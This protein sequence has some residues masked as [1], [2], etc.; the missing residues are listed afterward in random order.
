[1]FCGSWSRTLETEQLA[2]PRDECAYACCTMPSDI[3]MCTASSEKVCIAMTCSELVSFTT[4]H[5]RWNGHFFLAAAQIGQAFNAAPKS[6]P[7][8]YP[9]M[10]YGTSTSSTFTCA[11]A[12]HACMC[13][14]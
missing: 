2:P 1:M 4:T 6:F 14:D 3:E 8:I 11:C 7:C 9:R 5:G 12:V 13:D 10:P